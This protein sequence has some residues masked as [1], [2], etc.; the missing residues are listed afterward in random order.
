MELIGGAAR[1]ADMRNLP[2]GRFAPILLE[3]CPLA[4]EQNFS[5]PLVHPTLGDVRDRIDSRK[6]DQ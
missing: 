5:A 4:H 6:S 3:K 2:N 1:L